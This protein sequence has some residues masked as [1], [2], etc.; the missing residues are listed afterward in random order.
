MEEEARFYS[1]TGL[2]AVIITLLA[3]IFS[4]SI[5]LIIHT[6]IRIRLEEKKYE[7]P[8]SEKVFYSNKERI[9]L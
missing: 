6:Y 8:R 4:A 1:K 3:L 2:L 5:L 7:V 9:E